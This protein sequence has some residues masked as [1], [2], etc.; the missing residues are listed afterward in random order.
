MTVQGKGKNRCFT[1]TATCAL[2]SKLKNLLPHNSLT[3][4]AQGIIS[5]SRSWFVNLQLQ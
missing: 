2:F 5:S 4:I 3:L 1:V